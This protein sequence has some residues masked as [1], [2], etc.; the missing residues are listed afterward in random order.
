MR[1]RIAQALRLRFPP[2]AIFYTQERPAETKEFKPLCS[3]LL[4]AQAAKGK[5]AAL[6]L[7]TCG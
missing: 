5:T 1:S 2:L 3:M 7:G 4:V 6:T